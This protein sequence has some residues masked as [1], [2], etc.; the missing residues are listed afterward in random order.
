MN[1][2]LRSVWKDVV[3]NYCRRLSYYL[4]E[5]TKKN[6]KILIQE[7]RFP[8]LIQTRSLLEYEI[9]LITAQT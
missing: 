9:F 1:D 3:L 4:P 7:G 8:G 5:Y 6:D 2:E